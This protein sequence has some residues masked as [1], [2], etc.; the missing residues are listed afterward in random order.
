MLS[1]LHLNKIFLFLSRNQFR[2][3]ITLIILL[4]LLGLF[5][6]WYLFFSH[7]PT[8]TQLDGIKKTMCCEP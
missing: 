4:K 3:E 5:A 1:R 8:S 2:K 7:P 6:I